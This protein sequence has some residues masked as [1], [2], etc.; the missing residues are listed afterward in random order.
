MYVHVWVASGTGP[1]CLIHILPT[2]VLFQTNIP[3]FFGKRRVYCMLKLVRLSVEVLSG[4]LD[5]ILVFWRCLL[6]TPFGM[7]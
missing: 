6:S 7:C 5:P 4:V 1:L 3:L 2:L